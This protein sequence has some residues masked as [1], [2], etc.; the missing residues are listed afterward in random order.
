MLGG[1][2]T[3]AGAEQPEPRTLPEVVVQ[4][5]RDDDSQRHDASATRIVY[6][7]EELTQSN[8]LAVGDFLRKLPGVVVS[9]APGKGREAR[10]RGMKGY[11]QIL[12][13][14]EKTGGGKDRS[15]DVD[16]LPLEL[17][18]RIEIIRTP[19]ADMPNEGIAGTINIVMREAPEQAQRS[20]RLASGWS[21]SEGG[22]ATPLQ[23]SGLW[24][25]RTDSGRWLLNASYTERTEPSGTHTQVRE[26]DAT[27]T[28]TARREEISQEQL[29]NRELNLAPRWDW[30]DGSDRFNIAPMLQLQ[31][32]SRALQRQRWNGSGADFA[33][34]A[35][36]G[37]VQEAENKNQTALHVRGGW[38]RR[39]ANSGELSMDVSTRLGEQTTRS[40]GRE[41][42]AAGS[43]TQTTTDQID[44]RE[45][46]YRWS[47]KGMHP[48][49]DLHLLSWGLEN[50]GKRRVDERVRL[51]NGVP[52]T[53]DV[54]DTLTVR[55]QQWTGFAQDE[56]ELSESHTLVGGVRLSQLRRTSEAANG[57]RESNSL[58]WS[59]SLHHRWRV[60]PGHLVR[61]SISRSVK[62]PR[63]DDLSPQV[64]IA[65]G[66][67]P[68][69]FN[70]PDK[71]G[72][73]ELRPEQATALEV[74]W[75]N[76][77]PARAGTL[78][79]N[80]FWRDIQE[81]VE[82]RK[83]LES[84]RY[85]ERPYNSG[86]A[87]VWGLELDGRARLDAL[88]LDTLTLRGNYTRLYSQVRDS[89]THALRRMKEQP[90][91]IVNLGLEWRLPTHQLT[92]GGSYN[93]VPLLVR[94]PSTQETESA[95]RQVDLYAHRQLN[96]QLGLR[97]S[98][99]NLLQPERVIRKPT[100]DAAGV[101]NGE[102]Q[103]T[104]RGAR[105]IYVTLEGKW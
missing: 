76:A 90:D 16:Q 96:H 13:D 1:L 51:E 58:S 2:S 89:T 88:G 63:F 65:T 30:R 24:G 32:N 86:A 98:I 84:G 47:L 53:T 97:V 7:R 54:G 15:V 18:E 39:L 83:T 33:S 68:G 10:M 3:A 37:Q 46:S 36:N 4:V 74:G 17:I 67:G 45:Q 55:E 8:D 27:G 43:L 28:T 85:I 73:P 41:W 93:Y 95:Q 11:T 77:L 94:D 25:D 71:A 26:F 49:A 59:P 5:S 80:L 23:I 56:I 101:L 19:T 12:I 81:L 9:G 61:S 57:V 50:D 87:L 35:P 6:G 38:R 52:V 31:D 91:Y 72:N 42:D 78:G 75:E 20:V 40:L 70:N 14:G 44:A 22:E 48:V 62:L 21:Q 29:I 104:A 34:M 103:E 102:S 64:R 82:K 66:T 60:A 92:L 99:A 100:F 69:G 105:Q 79:A